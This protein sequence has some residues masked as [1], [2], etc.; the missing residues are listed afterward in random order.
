M[1]SPKVSVIIP[2]YRVESYIEKCVRSL[3]AQ[4]LHDLEYIFVDDYSP[5][6]SI[7]IIER[8]LEDFPE[9]KRQVKKICHS[10]NDGVAKSRQDGIDVALGEY[11]IHCDPDDWIELDMYELLYRKA[12]DTDADMV[13]C[14]YYNVNGA[15]ITYKSQQP[16]ELTSISVLESIAGINNINL[17]SG[18]WNKLIKRSIADKAKFPYDISWC[19]D[20]C[21]LLGLM[22]NDLKIA[23]INKPFYYYRF[24]PTS[25]GHTFSEKA[26]KKDINLI[27]HLKELAEKSTNKRYIACCKT[28]LILT[29]YWRFYK[30]NIS[31]TDNLKKFSFDYQKYI[32]LNRRLSPYSKV[33]L[34][35]SVN[36][37][38]REAKILLK[39]ISNL[40]IMIKKI[41]S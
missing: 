6:N 2:V 10:K 19:E 26:L 8:V 9:R 1:N 28:R 38:Q 13:I 37:L 30:F 4:T 34:F 41:C 29:I 14:D 7:S 33:I 35:L 11:I 3:F 25:I 27:D 23:Y 15:V 24:N 18:L 31:I 32:F 20:L 40:K 39:Y 17:H 21:Y 5:D 22:D 16:K 12:K 36:G